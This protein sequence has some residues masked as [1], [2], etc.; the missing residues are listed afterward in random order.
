MAKKSKKKDLPASKLYKKY[1]ARKESQKAS[2]D[3]RDRIPIGEKIMRFRSAPLGTSYNPHSPD[4]MR[5]PVDNLGLLGK[6]YIKE[7][8]DKLKLNK[9]DVNRAYG[10]QVKKLEKPKAKS[11]AFNGNDF[12]T[13]ANNYKEM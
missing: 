5:L 6:S 10:G 13:Q 7:Y 11:K 3:P 9:D 4:A 1:K 2:L 8:Y 12:V